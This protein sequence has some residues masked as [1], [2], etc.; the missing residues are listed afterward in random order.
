MYAHKQARIE[1]ALL[2]LDCAAYFPI[3]VM[4]VYNSWAFL[5]KQ[6]RFKNCSLLAF[7]ILTLF[8]V[9][10]RYITWSSILFQIKNQ[11]DSVEIFYIG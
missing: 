7:Y 5:I 2:S 9:I 3:F 1:V 4:A 10:S 6:G 8:I 11:N